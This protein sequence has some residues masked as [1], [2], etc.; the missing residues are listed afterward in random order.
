[1]DINVRL[2]PRQGGTPLLIEVSGSRTNLA[3]VVDLLAAKVVATLKI[4]ASATAWNAADEAAKFYE[5]AQ[6]ASHW[7]AHEE[8]E[9]AIESAWAL[10]KTDL[11][12]A[13]LRVRVYLA[14]LSAHLVVYHQSSELIDGADVRLTSPAVCRVVFKTG[15][16]CS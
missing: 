14:D 5:Q 2:T 4:D 10:G 8:A 6:W 1:M 15:I 12:G 7:G 3:A 13:S 16:F 11:D 9:T